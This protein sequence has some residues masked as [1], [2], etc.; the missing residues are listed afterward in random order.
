LKGYKAEPDNNNTDIKEEVEEK[1][2]T[3]KYIFT[4]VYTSGSTGTPKGAVFTEE[5]WLV[6]LHKS[7]RSLIEPLVTS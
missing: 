1:Q 5:A 6:A 4:I 3:D 2:N 7:D